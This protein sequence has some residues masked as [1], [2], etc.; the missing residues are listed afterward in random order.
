MEIE[1]F[2]NQNAFGQKF[3]NPHERKRLK[4]LAKKVIEEENEVVEPEE[5]PKSTFKTAIE[6]GQQG[7][8][9]LILDNGYNYM[10][11]MNDAL[12]DGKLQ[13][14]LTLLSKTSDDEVIQ[15]KNEKG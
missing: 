1:V 8:A 10:L 14:V 3:I 4:K 15:R 6:N 12:D 7:I 9:Y 5:E 2:N 13:L 11:A